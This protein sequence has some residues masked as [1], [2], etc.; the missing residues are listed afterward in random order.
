MDEET[1]I[2]VLEDALAQ[3]LKPLKGVPFSVVIK[4]LAEHAVIPIDPKSPE[5]A[6]L[7]KHLINVAHICG[8]ELRQTPIVRPRP[9][10]VGNDVEVY[11]QR[12]LGQVGL[13]C[14]RPTSAAGR[15]QA[16]GYP[17]LLIFDAA[18]RPTYLECKIFSADTV[19]TTM[20]SFY[21]SP[22]ETFKVSCDARHLLMSFQMHRTAI[23]GSVN[24]AFTASAF[25]LVDLHDLLCDMKYEFNS[26]NRKLYAEDL[27]LAEGKI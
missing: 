10:E 16:T 19:S 25:K 27:V 14:S 20:R 1:R 5:D 2:K 7:I 18:K 8:E 24:G 22:S 15:G 23:P 13:R 6:D 17:D 21:L 12:A 4:S 26:D 3:I 11:V 9:N